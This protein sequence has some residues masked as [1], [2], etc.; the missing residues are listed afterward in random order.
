MQ[1]TF[2]FECSSLYFSKH[3]KTIFTNGFLLF[4]ILSQS[5]ICVFRVS[6]CDFL[7]ICIFFYSTFLFHTTLIISWSI[8]N[9]EVARKMS[10]LKNKLKLTFNLAI[11]I[12]TILSLNGSSVILSSPYDYNFFLLSCCIP[13]YSGMILLNKIMYPDLKIDKLNGIENIIL[14]IQTN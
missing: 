10:T 5:R 13:M 1:N 12:Q 9:S 7:C 11:S 14:Q 4:Q 8:Q 6:C 3:G 2:H